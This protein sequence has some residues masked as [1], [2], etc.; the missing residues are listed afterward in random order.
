MKLQPDRSNIA[1]I[2][3]YGPGWV[4]V[5]QE[6]FEHSVI[7]TFDSQV[8]P[9]S[10]ERFEDLQASHFELLAAY[11]PE[12]VIFGSGHRMRFAPPVFLRSLIT[13]GIG[14]ETMDTQ[15]ACRTYNVLANEGRRVL[16]ALIVEQT[17]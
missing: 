17:P 1:M 11:E 12:L 16:T 2:N 13:Q 3:R 10:C 8:V 4:I 14:V 9:W 6:K 7:I 15:A 5:G